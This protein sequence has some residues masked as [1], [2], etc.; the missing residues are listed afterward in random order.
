MA[1]VVVVEIAIQGHRHLQ[2]PHVLEAQVVLAVEVLEAKRPTVRPEV[3]SEVA[4]VVAAEMVPTTMDRM[5]V[6]EDLVLVD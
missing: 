2:Q 5:R 3:H 4:V 1:V 6:Q